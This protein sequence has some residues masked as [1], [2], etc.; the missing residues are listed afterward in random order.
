MTGQAC[1]G[2]PW[3]SLCGIDYT[4]EITGEEAEIGG[5]YWL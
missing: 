5:S 1:Q 3:I 2:M 4:Q